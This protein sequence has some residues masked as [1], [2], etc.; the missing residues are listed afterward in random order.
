M[1]RRFRRLDII[2]QSTSTSP[3]SLKLPLFPLCIR[4]TV[5]LVH[6]SDGVPSQN[7]AF[8]MAATFCQLMAS[9]VLYR[10]EAISHWQIC[11]ALIPDGPPERFSKSLCTTQEISSSYD[12]EY[13]TGNGCNSTIF[14]CT[15]GGTCQYR[16]NRSSVMVEMS[17]LDGA[18]RRS[19]DLC[20]IQPKV[21]D[22][23]DRKSVV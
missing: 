3:I 11:S 20:V 7:A 12:I 18:T 2:F 15:R 21:N 9:G 1:I 8:K 13:S 14:G 19:S 22:N 23:K 4:T 16:D 17:N 10:V 5:C 6:Y